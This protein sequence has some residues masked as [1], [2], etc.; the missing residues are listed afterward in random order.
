MAKK[1]NKIGATISLRDNDFRT[2]MSNSVKRTDQFS[3]SAKKA[4]GSLRQFGK[5]ASGTGGILAGMSGKLVGAM[6]AFASVAALKS[7]AKDWMDA[8]KVQIEAETKLAAVMKNTKG[9]TDEHIQSIKD[10][11]SALQGVGVIGDEV[12]LS[13]VQQLA[14]YQ[15]QADTLKT[16][17]PGMADLA[18]QQKGLNATGQDMVNIGNMVGKVMMGQVGALSRAGISFSEAQE[19]VLKFGTEQEKAATLAQVLQENV[20]GVNKALRETDAGKQQAMLNTW[21]DMKEELGKKLLPLMGQFS[22]WFETKIPAIQATAITALDKGT[23]AFDRLGKGIGWVKDNSETL[24]PV[25]SGLVGMIAAMKIIGTTNAL[26][27]AWRTGTIV[28]TMAMYGLNAAMLA[29]PMTWLVV[30]IGLLVA[31]GVALY[32]NWDTVKN[33]A[34]QL[35]GTLDDKFRGGVNKIIR[36]LN[37]LIEKMNKIP[38]VN[39]SGIEEIGPSRRVTSNAV[40]NLRA[41]DGSHATGLRRVPHD[42]YIAELHKGERVLTKQEAKSAGRAVNVDIHINGSGMSVREIMNELVPQLKLALANM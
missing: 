33:K 7:A 21:G 23:A 35:W 27:T 17:M 6:A 16:L 11:A 5:D 34:D 25:A 24:I 38:G 13:G 41:I 26:M 14:T 29:N 1:Q 18:A 22:E 15:L 10:H 2:K 40:G 20:G 42:G 37:G 36:Y 4:G 31:A 12:Q 8:A 32:R 19:K 39:I 30:G 28:Q 3:N 9:I